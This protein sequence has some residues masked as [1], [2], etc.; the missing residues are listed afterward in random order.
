MGLRAWELVLM[1]P[2]FQRGYPVPDCPH[3]SVSLGEG[4]V[5]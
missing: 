1:L 4:Q 3:L 2:R 5:D